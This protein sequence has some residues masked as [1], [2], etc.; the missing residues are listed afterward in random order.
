MKRRMVSVLLLSF[1]LVPLNSPWAQTSLPTE[2]AKFGYAD[3]VLL[4]GKIVSMDDHGVNTNVGNTYEAMAVKGNKII[5]LG[6]S[7]KIKTLANADTKSFDLAGKMVMPGIIET[8]SH[9]YGGGQA[10]AALGIKSPDTG[11][12][13]SVMAG[14]DLET[15]RMAIE[16]GIRDAVKKVKPGEW[17][18]VGVRPNPAE[19][20]SSRQLRVWAVAE[21]METRARID[22][23]ADANPVIVK[24]DTRANL[25]SMAMEQVMKVLPTFDIFLDQAMGAQYTEASKKGLVGS[26]EQSAIQ[27]EIWYRNQPLSL[28]AEMV[29][30]Q[31]EMTAAYGITTFS[32]RVPLPRIMDVFSEL[33]REKALP[34]RFGAL[35]EVHR[36]PNDPKIT[37]QI[38]KMTGNLTGLGSDWF[39]LHGV[40][41]ERWDTSYPEICLG[42]DVEAPPNIKRREVCPE[43]G[44]IWWDTLQNAME[45]GWRLAGIHGEGSDGV[46]RFIQMIEMA[47]KNTKMSVDD[48]RKLRMTV[49]HAPAIG[50]MKDVMEGLA[51][52]GIIVS[53]SPGYFG[54][55][56]DFIKGYGPKVLPFMMPLKTLIAN[57]VKVVGQNTPRNVGHMW[58]RFMDRKIGDKGPFLPEEGLDRVTVA[59]MWTVWASEY[60]MKENDLGSLELGKMA[61]FVVLDRDYFTIPQND[62]NN[63]RP[64]MT[65]VD[66]TIK[67]LDKVYSD[68]IG[69]QPV[70]YQFAPDHTPWNE[71][72]MGGG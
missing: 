23:V 19:D 40:A 62:I 37:R 32:S 45:S 58:L 24:N 54:D 57:G 4:N 44:S 30:R 65:V 46:R 60:V 2:V 71:G 22:R 64:Q 34:I 61:D 14:K 56:P 25:N 7:E 66:G 67:Y 68:K 33:N 52:Y 3:M 5:A 63:I 18:V 72:E 27:W 17:V 9:L 26:Q 12:Q 35:Y 1:I 31:L 51:K 48:I 41:S 29:R 15:T 11:I 53:A 42:K 43:P 36:I 59:K 16:N 70:G 38:Y 47:A 55:T 39:W 8:H 69:M 13:V 21:D 10:A 49:E 50:Q 6:T 28:L 20:V